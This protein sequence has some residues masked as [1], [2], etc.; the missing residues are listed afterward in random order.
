MSGLVMPTVSALTAGVLL[1]FQT[2]LMLAAAR[3]RQRA[4]QSLGDGGDSDLERAVRRHGNFAENAAIFLIGVTLLE[5]LGGA[6]LWVEGLCAIFVL[7]RL[8]H[9][10]GLSMK[11]TVNLF[12]FVGI[13]LTVAVDIT[14]GVR[15]VTLALHQLP[16]LSLGLAQV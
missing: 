13:V 7:G 5:M 3:G 15:L 1:I 6:R 9:A 2:L 12:R 4:R 11:R 14:L 16:A 10:L 8:S